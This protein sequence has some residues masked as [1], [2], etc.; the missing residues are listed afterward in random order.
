LEEV[1]E[2]MLNFSVNVRRVWNVNGREQ[3]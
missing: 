3:L 1:L 2:V